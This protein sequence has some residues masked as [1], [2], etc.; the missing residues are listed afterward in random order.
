MKANIL[1]QKIVQLYKLSAEQL[2]KQRQYDYSLR[3]LKMVIIA[4]GI[5]LYFE[6]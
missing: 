5:Y 3:S 1:G 4:A 2:S 6:K